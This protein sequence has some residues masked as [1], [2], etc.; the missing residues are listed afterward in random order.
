MPKVTYTFNLP[1]D[2]SD[3]R[4]CRKAATYLGVIADFTKVIRDKTKYGTT[5]ESNQWAPVSALWWEILKIEGV[6]PYGD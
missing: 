5:K 3:L 1:A 2:E 6:D 4:I